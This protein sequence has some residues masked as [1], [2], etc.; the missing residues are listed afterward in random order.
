MLFRSKEFEAESV[1]YIIMGQLGLDGLE[2][3]RGYI[4]AWIGNDGNKADLTEKNFTR[5][6]GACD[7]ILKAGSV[8]TA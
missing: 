1:A 6:L 5:I 7:K 2:Y 4:K 8:A 3:S